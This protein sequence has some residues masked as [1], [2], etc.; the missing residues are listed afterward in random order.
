MSSESE[1]ITSHPGEKQTA[2][3]NTKKHSLCA[4]IIIAQSRTASK[5]VY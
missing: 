3:K 4:E 2:E 5:C 1:E